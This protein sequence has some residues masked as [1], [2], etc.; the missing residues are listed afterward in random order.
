MSGSRLRVL[1]VTNMFHEEGARAFRGIFVTQQ[2]NALLATGQVELDRVLVAQGKG[3]LDYLV[4]NRRVRDAWDRGG[5]DL[6]HVH[7]GLTGLAALSLPSL[8]PSVFTF[9]GS[10]INSTVQRAISFATARRARR[11]IYVAGRLAEQ[12]PDDRNVVLPNGIDFEAC[13]PADRDEACRGL[14]LDPVPRRVLFGGHPEN[15]VKGWP[16]FR[17]VMERVRRVRPDAE[18]LV[19]S[20]PGQP[21][22]RVVAKLNAADVLLFTSRRGSEGSPTVVKEALV[23]GLPVVS[24]DVGDVGEMLDGVGPGGVVPWPAAAGEV[25]RAEWLDQL[26]ARVTG[27][28]DSGD[29][30]DGRRKRDFLRQERIAERTLEVYRDALGIPVVHPIP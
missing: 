7:Y 27:I 3:V 2:W 17:E 14:G 22:D 25:A 26:A 8:V 1:W 29:R 19:L 5:F 23:V 21:Y 10:D 16:V 13:Q 4:A 20:E 12:W 18:E 6:V 11:R 24:V 15:A 28:L 9:Y 30:S